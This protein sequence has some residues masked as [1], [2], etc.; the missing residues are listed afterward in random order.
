MKSMREIVADCVW[1]VLESDTFNQIISTKSRIQILI[2]EVNKKGGKVT[3]DYLMGSI[4][5]NLTE[6][7]IHII[8]SHSV[9]E[10]TD[11]ARSCFVAMLIAYLREIEAT[12]L[13][14]MVPNC[15]VSHSV[16]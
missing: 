11:C 6:S 16:N 14:P 9:K 7:E 12:D 8:S 1:N 13:V 4:S 10:I 3:D 15:I 5:R 2:D